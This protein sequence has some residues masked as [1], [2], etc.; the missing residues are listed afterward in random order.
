MRNTC[1]R[2]LAAIYHVSLD[3][4]L[5]S[6]VRAV[7]HN[8]QR[9]HVRNVCTGSKVSARNF[10]HNKP[11]CGT[12]GTCWDATTALHIFASVATSL[13]LL[14]AC[15]LFEC[16]CFDIQH[17]PHLWNKTWLEHPYLSIHSC[18]FTPSSAALSRVVPHLHCS[19]PCPPVSLQGQQQMEVEVTLKPEK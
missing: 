11:P 13:S 12:R 17:W 6:F 1:W 5:G 4:S 7:Y 8:V 9:L 14:L 10:C 16:C 19:C 15:F 18:T 3:L 2:I